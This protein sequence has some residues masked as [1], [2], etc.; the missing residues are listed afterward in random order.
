MKRQCAGEFSIDNFVLLCLRGVP[1][2][3][4]VY[5]GTNNSV[6]SFI[7]ELPGLSCAQTSGQ[8]DRQTRKYTAKNI[9]LYDEVG[10][11]I[12][13][14]A[15]LPRGRI[16]CCTPSVCASVRPSVRLSVSPLPPIFSNRKALESSNLV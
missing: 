16:M 5:P 8:T 12:I 6:S 3:S 2:I 15:S 4:H 9:F 7:A 11:I 14:Y 1:E 10:G 13:Y